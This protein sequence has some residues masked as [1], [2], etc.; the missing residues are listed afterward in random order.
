MCD[1]AC[2]SVDYEIVFC[3][4]VMKVWSLVFG[5]WKLGSVN[6]FTAYDMLNHNGG[7]GMSSKNI[8]IWQAVVW[9]TGYFIWRNR[10]C[11]VFGKKVESHMKFFQEVQLRSCEWIVRRSS[12][13]KLR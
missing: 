13:Y 11:R 9:T 3:I 8:A 10:N 2:E 7:G 12:K 5:W 4:E 6:A 1:N